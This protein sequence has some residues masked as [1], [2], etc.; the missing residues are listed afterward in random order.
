VSRSRD[1]R[2]LAEAL[3]Q[4]AGVPV[5]VTWDESPGRG[6][7]WCWC[8]SWQDG[9]TVDQ[10]RAW[11]RDMATLDV[12]ALSLSRHLSARAWAVQLVRHVADGGGLED[13]FSFR[14]ELEDR[15][16]AI[17]EPDAP[18]DGQEAARAEALL[19]L[20]HPH[21]ENRMIDVLTAHGLAAL[22]GEGTLPQ[23][24]TALTAAREAKGL[25]QGR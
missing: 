24:V 25:A 15:M 16:R 5:A 4:R 11:A 12:E 13:P 14:Y 1:A 23:G 17:S 19:R 9:P 18:I 20:A 21:D 2:R 7:R 3:S 8:T 10:V 6:R 22:D